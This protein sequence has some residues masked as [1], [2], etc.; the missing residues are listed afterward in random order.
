MSFAAK[1]IKSSKNNRLNLVLTKTKDGLDAWWYILVDA[2]KLTAFF[3]AMEK[4][5]VDL[6]DF[7]KILKSGYGKTPPNS[8]KQEML[9]TYGFAERND[10][11]ISPFS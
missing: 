6:A 7:G 10:Y 5:S 2:P 8:V 11:S 1:Y 4:G 3:K 9:E